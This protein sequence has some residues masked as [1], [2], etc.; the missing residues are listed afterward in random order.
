M[1]EPRRRSAV[2]RALR[3]LF[4]GIF[5]LAALAVGAFAYLMYPAWRSYPKADYPPVETQSEKNA[6]DLD[7]LSRLPEIDRSFSKEKRRSFAR[8]IERITPKSGDYDRAKLTLEAAKLVALADNGHTNVLTQLGELSFRSVPIRLGTFADGFFVVKAEGDAKDLLGAQL[9]AVNEHSIDQLMMAFRPYVGGPQTLLHQ[10]LPRFLVAPELLAALGINGRADN[11]YYRFRFADGTVADRLL[12]A[13]DTK[14]KIEDSPYWPVRDL[15][16][17]PTVNDAPDWSYVLDAPPL[18]L[19]KPDE[20]YWHTYVDE[21]RVLYLQLNRMRDQ[22]RQRLADH[23]DTVID[24]VRRRGTKF[25]AVDLRYNR[26]GDYTQAADF[27]RHLIDV[28]P[29]DGRVFILTSGSTFSAAI[30]IAS[31]LKYFGGARATLIGEPMGDRGQFWG[32]GDRIVLPN[33]KIVVRYATAYHDWENGCSLAQIT[34][35]FLFNYLYGA[36][37]G[38]LSPQVP[39]SPRYAD[40]AAGRDAVMSE[41]LKLAASGASAAAAPGEAGTNATQ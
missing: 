27:S 32:E 38:S 2:G 13:T 24:T 11:G 1:S 19:S 37:P 15:S 21:G 41:V 12:S 34:T 33:S 29:P 23:L 8:G 14:T 40:Y 17:V 22:G 4:L 26:G 7:Y 10:H 35:C 36:A 25:V 39:V 16:P 6:Q 3:R 31:R 5:V 30:S 18:Y 28:I 9:I 20:N